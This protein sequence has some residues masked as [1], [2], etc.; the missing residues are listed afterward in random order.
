[1]VTIYHLK[2][3]FLMPATV[4]R[5][6]KIKEVLLKNT[7]VVIWSRFTHATRKWKNIKYGKVLK[8][9]PFFFIWAMQ[10]GKNTHSEDRVN[11][12]ES[13]ILNCCVKVTM[14]NLGKIGN[15]VSENL[16]PKFP[17]K[18]RAMSCCPLPYCLQESAPLVHIFCLTRLWM[19]P[20]LLS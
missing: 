3:L 11:L 5:F 7:Q 19:V 18:G 15:D 20:Y 1:M 13:I 16:A 10:F 12:L 8:Y 4:W 14:A 2:Q 17:S 9:T 6:T